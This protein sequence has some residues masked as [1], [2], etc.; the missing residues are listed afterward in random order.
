MTTVFDSHFASAGFPM[1]LDNF[2]ESIAYIPACGKRR[3]ITAII[4]RDPPAIFDAAGNAVLPLATIRVYNSNRSGISSREADIGSD[5]V[6]FALKIGD[7]KPKTFSFYT[8]L[9]QDS[10]V[11]V[12]AV[13]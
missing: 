4:E 1:L 13:I 5:Q 2:G 7:V 11:T 10:G 12:W 9:S 3:V 8:M 6:E